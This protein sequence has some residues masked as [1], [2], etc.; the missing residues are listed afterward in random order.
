MYFFQGLNCCSDSSISFHYMSPV[1]MLKM[2]ILLNSK[3]NYTIKE[4][5]YDLYQYN[6][7]IHL[8]TQTTT[9]ITKN[10]SIYFDK[11]EKNHNSTRIILNNNSRKF[12]TSLNKKVL[13]K[14]YITKPSVVQLI[15]YFHN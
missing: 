6:E 3:S 15:T 11:N 5:S 10:F 14:K 13:L 1:E 8:Q 2:S 9:K 7:T 12:K 4:L